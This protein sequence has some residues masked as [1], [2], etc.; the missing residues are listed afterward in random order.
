MTRNSVL[1]CRDYNG[2][3][4]S[5]YANLIYQKSYGADMLGTTEHVLKIGASYYFDQFEENFMSTELNR[6]R[7]VPGVF[8]EYAYNP[9]PRFS[10]IAGLR[11]DYHSAFKTIFSPRLHLKVRLLL[12]TL[13]LEHRHQRVIERPIFIPN[14]RC[15]G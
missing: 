15:F 2:S 6:I 1:G 10:M 4:E 5:M 11:T 13:T 7:N 12:K 9:N 3:Q 14:N 8:T